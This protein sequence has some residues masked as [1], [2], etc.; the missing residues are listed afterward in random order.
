MIKMKKSV[1]MVLC[2]LLVVGTTLSTTTVSTAE[3]KK[4]AK[5]YITETGSCYHRINNCGKTNPKKTSKVTE[6]EAKK[7]GLKKCSKCYR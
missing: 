7:M 6:K 1:I 3:A 5:V 2:S 4:A